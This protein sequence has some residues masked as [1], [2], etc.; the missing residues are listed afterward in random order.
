MAVKTP[1][2]QEWSIREKLCLASAVMRS[3]DQNWYVEVITIATDKFDD[4]SQA[5]YIELN[6]TKAVAMLLCVA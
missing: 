6:K 5:I 2:C 1:P 3:G 4:N